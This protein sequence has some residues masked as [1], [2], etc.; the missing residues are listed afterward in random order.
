MVFFQD[1]LTNYPVE[2]IQNRYFNGDR[3][4]SNYVILRTAFEVVKFQLPDDD[5][6]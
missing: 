6:I 3:T 2:Q 4:E 1:T 5:F